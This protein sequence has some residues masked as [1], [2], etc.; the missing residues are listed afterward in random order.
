MHVSQNA[1]VYTYIYIY[2]VQARNEKETFYNIEIFQQSPCNSDITLFMAYEC[3]LLSVTFSRRHHLFL[4]YSLKDDHFV[5]NQTI[6]EQNNQLLL[7]YFMN[8]LHIE[9]FLLCV[10]FF[11]IELLN[12]QGRKSICISFVCT[13]VCT[14][15]YCE[16][17]SIKKINNWHLKKQVYSP[18]S[19]SD[20]LEW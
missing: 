2:I 12:V 1:I 5:Y 20:L 8:V 15:L 3:S 11:N 16:Y 17:F 14:K 9:L 7:L 18:L 19:P 6:C 10:Y 4:S 13:Y